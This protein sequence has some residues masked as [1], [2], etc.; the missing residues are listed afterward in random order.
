VR[1]KLAERSEVICENDGSRDDTFATLQRLR[2]RGPT[3]SIIN[4]TRN[5]GKEIPLT[6]GLDLAVAMPSSSLMQI[7]KT[8]LS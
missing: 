2:E 3:I 4:L 1:A 5:F 7:R 6:A 8:R